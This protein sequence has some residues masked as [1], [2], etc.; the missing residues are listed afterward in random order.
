MGVLER[1]IDACAAAGLQLSAVHPPGTALTS[2]LQRYTELLTTKHGLATALNSTD[3]AFQHLA[4]HFSGSGSGP[5]CERCCKPRAWGCE[6]R[7]ERLLTA[8]AKLSVPSTEDTPSPAGTCRGAPRR[9]AQ[10]QD[11]PKPA[12]RLGDRLGPVE[13]R[14][15][16]SHRHPDWA[17]AETRGV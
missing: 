2:W 12:N 5:P 11:A 16:H 4:G 3:P 6:I 15:L 17:L 1:E 13:D 8:I 7:A 10:H 14:S 9:T